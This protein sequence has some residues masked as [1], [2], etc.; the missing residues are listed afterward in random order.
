MVINNKIDA[1]NLK[2]TPQEIEQKTQKIYH[3]VLEESKRFDQANFTRIATED[4]KHLFELY[5]LHFLNR[6]FG[7]GYKEKLFFR[8]S[9]RMTRA[10]GKATY[11][12]R[13]RVY[14]ISLSIPLIF[15][16]FRD[17][18][19]EGVVNGIVCHDRLQATMRVL[20]E[21]TISPEIASKS[22][23]VLERDYFESKGRSLI[24]VRDSL[25]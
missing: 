12:K 19:R 18:K 23:G 2:Y 11:M 10:A 21:H 3:Q 8:L 5:D 7:N 16:S 1:T 6:F 4:L 15:Q 9:Q 14:I 17:I 24:E 20:A 25:K 13:S 22:E